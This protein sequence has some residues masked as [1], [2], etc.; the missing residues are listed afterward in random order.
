[1]VNTRPYSLTTPRLLDLFPSQACM[2][3]SATRNE[4]VVTSLAHLRDIKTP[5]TE[6][7]LSINPDIWEIK[8]LLT[9]S[10]VR[11]SQTRL[12][13]PKEY[14]VP[15][16]LGYLTDE[17][18]I[19]V[20]GANNQGLRINVYDRDTESTHQLTLKK[21]HSSGSY[22]LINNWNKDFVKRR[23]LKAGKLIGLFWNTY[24]TRLQFCVLN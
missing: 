3:S 14:V 8:K 20:E 1:M 11:N 24:A 12:M 4:R 23:Q 5:D 17:E 13:L 9:E 10:D 16:I 19:M 7:T 22:V 6:L 15:H 21:W 18:R 2:V